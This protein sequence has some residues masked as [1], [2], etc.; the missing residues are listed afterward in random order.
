MFRFY[1]FLLLFFQSY[2]IDAESVYPVKDIPDSLLKNANAVIRNSET[3]YKVISDKRAILHIEK[4]ITILNK[5][6]KDY[7]LFIT[8][9]NKNLKLSGIS[10]KVYDSEGKYLKRAKNSEIIDLSIVSGFSLYEENRVKLY[11]PDI[12]EYPYTVVFTY[13]YTFDGIVYFPEWIP[14][15]YYDISVETATLNVFAGK[16]AGIRFYARNIN[17]T[18]AID[19]LDDNVHYSWKVENLPAF[20]KEPFSPPVE[21][22]KPVVYLA[23]AN[24]SYEGF[25]GDMSTWK[26]FGLWVNGLLEGRNDLPDETRQKIKEIVASTTDTVEMIRRI[27]KYVQENTRYVSIQLGI[28]GFRPFKTSTVDKVGYGDCKALSFYTKSLL[29]EAGIKANYTLV[30]AGTKKEE[31]IKDFPSQ[32]FNHVI[33]NVPLKNDTVWLECTNQEMPFGFLGDFTDDRLALNISDKGGELIRTPEYQQ[34]QNSKK[35]FAEMTVNQDGSIEGKIVL[36]L[37]GLM[38][39]EVFRFIH[40]DAKEQKKWLHKNLNIPEFDIL[41]FSVTEAGDRIPEAVISLDLSIPKYCSKTGKRMFIPLNMLDKLKEI[42]KDDDKRETDILL[43]RSFTVS[44]SVIFNLP[45]S[46]TP[47]HIPKE[48]SFNSTFGEYNSKSKADSTRILYL[49]N[50]KVNKGHYSKTLYP[51]FKEFYRNV[52]NADKTKLVLK[53]KQ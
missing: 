19:S 48:K 44:D 41:N 20:E 6:G 36:T 49:R 10:I 51:E 37:T 4:A 45:S 28:G 21:K 15:K 23:P 52:V 22:Y 33:L 17:S 35:C 47:E 34:K 24:F 31:I 11:K 8:F 25:E 46:Y 14:Q 43:Y 27:Y 32:Q 26:D 2:L 42:P 40:D 50:I 38:Y 3:S 29:E 30:K 13:T 53:K 7:A 1:I 9:Y 39:D 18:P 16:K 12:S 5:N